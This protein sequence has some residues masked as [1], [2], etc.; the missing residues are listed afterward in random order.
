M[1]IQTFQEAEWDGEGLGVGRWSFRALN[2]ASP[3]DTKKEC[4]LLQTLLLALLFALFVLNI[5]KQA[6]RVP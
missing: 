3:S 6:A 4:S 1:S 5:F 2:R